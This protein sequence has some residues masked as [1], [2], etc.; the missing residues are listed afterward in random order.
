MTTEE[1][2]AAAK[3][4]MAAGRA[5]YA[6]PAPAPAPAVR[7]VVTTPIVQTPPAPVLRVSALDLLNS[8]AKTIREAQPTMTK[9][10]AF[11]EAC[12]RHPDLYALSRK[13]NVRNGYG[14]EVRR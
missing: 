2:R 13:E 9:P 8:H 11:L 10:D 14:R 12:K 4:S 3:R 1:A 7:P 5:R 6:Q